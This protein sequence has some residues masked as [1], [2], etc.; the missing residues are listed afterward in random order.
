[1]TWIKYLKDNL[2][3]SSHDIYKKRKNTLKKY[4]F[5][6]LL[7]NSMR[8]LRNKNKLL[9]FSKE[10]NIVKDVFAISLKKMEIFLLYNYQH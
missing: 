8:K 2:N 4:L 6:S 7:K 10:A 9:S 3:I 5:F 1:M